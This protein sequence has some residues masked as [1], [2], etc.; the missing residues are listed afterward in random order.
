MEKIRKDFTL[1]ELL[2]VIAIIAILASMLLPALNKARETAKLSKCKNNLKQIGTVAALYANDYND[3][4]LPKLTTTGGW[5]DMTW[6]YPAREYT[7]PNRS[8]SN[9]F[10]KQ[11]DRLFSCPSDNTS[12]SQRLKYSYDGSYGINYYLMNSGRKVSF[13]KNQSSI[14]QFGEYNHNSSYPA[15]L[16]VGGVLTTAGH[17]HNVQYNTTFLDGHCESINYGYV[18]LGASSSAYPWKYDY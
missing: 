1:I 8:G 12:E 9:Y 5:D 16:L 6:C 10:D 13:Y 15:W 18:A 17:Y 2:V 14:M 4:L 11:K 3:H 7:R